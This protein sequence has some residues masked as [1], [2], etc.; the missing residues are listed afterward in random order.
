MIKRIKDAAKARAAKARK[1]SR[2][3]AGAKRAS[4]TQET[5]SS[6]YKS[7]KDRKVSR[8][9]RKNAPRRAKRSREVQRP[10]KETASTGDKEVARRPRRITRQPARPQEEINK[11][12]QSVAQPITRDDN[13]EEQT[14]ERQ[15]T[16]EEQ[17]AQA[18]RQAHLAADPLLIHKEKLTVFSNQIKKLKLEMARGEKNMRPGLIEIGRLNIESQH[19][20]ANLKPD[21]RS[22]IIEHANHSDTILGN[23]DMAVWTLKSAVRL[24]PESGST[25]LQLAQLFEEMQEGAEA[26]HHAKLAE[27]LFRKKN[28]KKRAAEAKTLGQ[29]IYKKFTGKPMPVTYTASR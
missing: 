17:L 29:T 16:K 22:K 8:K 1:P 15:Q 14:E 21:E 7:G 24:N 26:I 20:Q 23:F 4:K 19:Y 9:S 25:H 27:H 28:Q 18:K 2:F 5:K 3:K 12:A 6:R 13:A 11:L 10:I